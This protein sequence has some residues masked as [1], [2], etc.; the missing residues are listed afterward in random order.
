LK[1]TNSRIQILTHKILAVP[2]LVILLAIPGFFNEIDMIGMY[3]EFLDIPP[4]GLVPAMKLPSF[5][6]S[7]SSRE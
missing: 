7:G 6:F 4:I 2:L 3:P 1:S 5:Q